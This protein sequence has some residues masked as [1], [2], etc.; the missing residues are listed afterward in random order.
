MT[1][2]RRERT[3]MGD[4]QNISMQDSLVSRMMN[5]ISPAFGEHRELDTSTG[6]GLDGV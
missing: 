2:L 1:S 3:G 6:R 5:N 4:P